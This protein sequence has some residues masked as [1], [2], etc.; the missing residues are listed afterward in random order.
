M[1]ARPL[2]GPHLPLLLAVLGLGAP[3]ES[4]HGA[5]KP[6]TN[7]QVSGVNTNLAVTWAWDNVNSADDLNVTFSANYQM[8]KRKNSESWRNLT[9]CHHVP[10]HT[11]NFTVEKLHFDKK[12]SVRVRAETWEGDS[13]WSNP[14]TFTPNSVEI[15]PPA[16]VDVTSIRGAILINISAPEAKVKRKMWEEEDLAYAIILWKNNSNEEETRYTTSDPVY[17]VYD[18]VPGVTYCLK[19]QA[20][21]IQDRKLGLFSPVH[22]FKK[23][24]KGSEEQP[25]PENVRVDALNTK[26]VLKWEWNYTR[27]PNVTF[28]V[29]M[30]SSYKQMNED[31][32]MKVNLCENITTFECDLSLKLFFY[33]KYHFRVSAANGGRNRTFSDTVTFSPIHDTEIGPPSEVKV[34]IVKDVLQIV[35]SAPENMSEFYQWSYYHL[36][37]WKNPLDTQI[38]HYKEKTPF[39]VIQELEA[40]TTY[41]LKVQAVSEN[42]SKS[43]SF[44]EA[45]CITTTP[46]P[47]RFLKT[48]G[49]VLILIGI[50]ILSFLA[51]L[52]V[53]PLQRYIKH[54]FFPS[55]K[56]PS[57]IDKGMPESPTNNQ[58]LLQQEEPTDMCYIINNINCKKDILEINNDSKPFKAS[59]RDSGNYSNEDEITGDIVSA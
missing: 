27:E 41:C 22:C 30:L 23:Q 33:G 17:P 21:Q 52:C 19:V 2:L 5:L 49:V 4:G 50:T 59:S 48:W 1:A 53:C 45:Q 25:V 56:L 16:A 6:P 10:Y 11:C 24:E 36:I 9:G 29:E 28:A 18:L 32:W 13:Q 54:I 37:L 14:I 42:E 12:Y 43:G 46:D 58:F 55:G 7:V 40:S 35:C 51:Y 26:Y 57:S 8:V 20:F 38:K 47:Q 44:S 15:G 34:N 39:F 3:G 31:N